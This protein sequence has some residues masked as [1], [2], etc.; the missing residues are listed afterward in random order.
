MSTHNI[1]FHGE[2]GKIFIWIPHL[3]RALNACQKAHFLMM[4]YTHF[5]GFELSTRKVSG[6]TEG[7]NILHYR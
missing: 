5:S 2:S 6:A 1:C 7:R 4:W 3:S